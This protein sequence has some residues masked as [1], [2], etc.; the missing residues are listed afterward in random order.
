MQAD[1]TGL[2]GED[3][4]GLA[5]WIPGPTS[6]AT[7][8][9]RRAAWGILDRDD[10]GPPARLRPVESGCHAGSGRALGQALQMTNVLRD[11]AQDLRIGRCYLPRHALAA[12]GLAP[13]D[14]LDPA[15]MPRLRPVLDDLVASA[16]DGFREAWEYTRAIPRSEVRLRLACAWPMLIGLRTL[17]ASGR[18]RPCSTPPSRLRS[19]APPCMGCSCAPPRSSAP[20]PGWA[21]TAGR[22]T[23]AWTAVGDD[24]TPRTTG[25]TV[26]AHVWVSGR[27]QGVYFRAY[28]EDEAGFRKV[29]GWI[30]NAPDGRV[31]A[32]F[33]GAPDGHRGDDPVVSP[34]FARLRRHRGG[35]CPG[36]GPRRDRFCR[37]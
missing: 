35:G 26:R 11:V 27:V 4:A 1:L 6:T 36:S 9:T 16:R 17:D 34:G 8:I 7:P 24:V 20:T 22:W 32:V 29:T 28:A 5:A 30:R 37:A 2:P 14:L 19:R 31:E 21:V 13:A 33:E 10:H 25:T 23:V 15:S 12:H 18:P 3:A